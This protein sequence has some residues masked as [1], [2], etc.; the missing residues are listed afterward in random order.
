MDIEKIKLN[1]TMRKDAVKDA[2]QFK[3]KDAVKSYEVKL[4]KAVTDYVLSRKD[5]KAAI[6]AYKNLDSNMRSLV[7]VSNTITLS[8]KNGDRISLK[9]S[10]AMQYLMYGS[11]DYHRPFLNKERDGYAYNQYVELT[12]AKPLIT[13]DF[14]FKDK[15]PV[16]LQK[17]FDARK[18]L[19][20]EI[21]GFAHN[22]YHALTQVKS[23]KEV[24]EYIPA[25]EQFIAVPEKEFTKMVPYSFFNKVNKSINLKK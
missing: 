23:I 3:F 9:I 15:T 22:A 16:S 4:L 5:N 20:A 2:I 8:D 10:N 24:R 19:M 17:V 25:L 7:R 14:T 11:N 6:D 13:T 12:F 1:Q 18:L 21:D